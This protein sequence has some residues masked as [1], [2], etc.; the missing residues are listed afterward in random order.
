MLSSVIC[1]FNLLTIFYP[2]MLKIMHRKLVFF[3]VAFR[4]ARVMVDLPSPVKVNSGL[5]AGG[6]GGQT[7]C[8]PTTC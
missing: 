5:M 6:A 8:S 2:Q 3:I 4:R 7:M 1:K